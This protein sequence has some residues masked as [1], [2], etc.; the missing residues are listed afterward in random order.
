MGKSYANAKQQRHENDAGATHA[1]D[2]AD[3]QHG[4]QAGAPGAGYLGAA[5]KSRT[6]DVTK[7]DNE[8]KSRDQGLDAG[9]SYGHGAFRGAAAA[10][11]QDATDDLNIGLY[12]LEGDIDPK[13]V[14]VFVKLFIQ[15]PWLFR[16]GFAYGNVSGKAEQ[17]TEGRGMGAQEKAN[18]LDQLNQKVM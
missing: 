12:V 6:S 14:D 2:L 11:M 8:G 4:Q 15:M 16:D 17:A 1:P 3:P 7:I 9:Q 10:F 5:A 13:A 18:A